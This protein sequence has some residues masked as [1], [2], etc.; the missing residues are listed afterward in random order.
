MTRFPLTAVQLRM[1]RGR[2]KWMTGREVMFWEVAVSA[3]KLK[4]DNPCDGSY[5]Y[6]I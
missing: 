1:T 4:K 2:K 6:S 3:S 5:R